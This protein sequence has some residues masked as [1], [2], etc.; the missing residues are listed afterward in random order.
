MLERKAPKKRKKIPNPNKRFI[1]LSDI[2][3]NGQNLKQSDLVVLEKIGTKLGNDEE[4]E[5][6]E[7][8]EAEESPDPT[9][10]YTRSG[11]QIRKPLSL[12]D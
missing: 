7:A 12:G 6:E 1:Q 2:L 8:D 3:G 5:E 4:E 11:R 9:P 10:I